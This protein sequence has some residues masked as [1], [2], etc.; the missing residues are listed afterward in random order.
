MFSKSDR[1]AICG[2]F[3][4]GDLKHRLLF[5]DRIGVPG[6]ETIKERLRRHSR[7]D[8]GL[9][10]AN[11]LEFLQSNNIVFAAKEVLEIEADPAWRAIIGAPSTKS[12]GR[13]LSEGQLEFYAFKV[14]REWLDASLDR[15][16]REVRGT[17]SKPLKPSESMEVVRFYRSRLQFE[18]RLCARYVHYAEGVTA[19]AVFTQPLIIPEE[20]QHF[21]EFQ[22]PSTD[23]ADIVLDKLPMPSELTPWEAILDFKA[24]TDAQGYL[25]GLKVWMVDLA[26]QKLSVNEASEKLDWLLF[27][28]KK[29]LEMHKLSYRWGTLGG[30]FVAA[31]EVLEDL[32]KIKWGKAAG[33]VVSIFDKRV[34]LMKAE[35]SNPAKEV[36]YIVKAQEQFG[37]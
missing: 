22:Q 11:D 5:F 23:V 32:A 2:E 27:Q 30:T 20:L 19:S 15:F 7:G 35:L 18:V 36:S 34:E 9:A 4:P 37:E 14:S 33:A 21:E 1:I 10:L 25:Q 8:R 29:H 3:G 13:R 12:K 17:E 28:H 24:D 31:A 6:L 16:A 26:R